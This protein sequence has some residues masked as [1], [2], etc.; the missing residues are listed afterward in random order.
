M[1]L[2]FRAWDKKENKMYY[3]VEKTYDN[4]FGKPPMSEWSFGEVIE[5]AERGEY[6]LMQYTGLCD[7]NESELY[8]KDIVK[9]YSNE[10]E[11]SPMIGII[12]WDEV[13][14]WIFD[15]EDGVIPSID[16]FGEYSQYGSVFCGIEIEKVGNIF[17]NENLLTK[18][19]KE[20]YLFGE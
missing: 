16:I 6:I 1:I 18:K 13:G 5:C 7:K 8:D 9:A 12:N 2:K 15:F 11:Y 3:D 10:F 19:L 20:K 14:Q 17:E 4:L